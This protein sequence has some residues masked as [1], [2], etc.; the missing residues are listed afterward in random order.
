MTQS[1][2]I[3]QIVDYDIPGKEQFF[4]H[5]NN[6]GY[7][8]FKSGDRF[9]YV[10]I[11]FLDYNLYVSSSDNVL[12]P[13]EVNFIKNQ[14]NKVDFICTNC[15]VSEFLT[16]TNPIAIKAGYDEVFYDKVIT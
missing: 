2:S 14:F 1:Q 16:L 3:K 11:N 5:H 13:Q 15:V 4:S 7:R 8:L 12:S 10:I 9:I 6:N